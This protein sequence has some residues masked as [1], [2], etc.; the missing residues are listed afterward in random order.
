LRQIST[1]PESETLDRLTARLCSLPP[2]RNGGLN[3][4]LDPDSSPADA[5]H[6]NHLIDKLAIQ[7]QEKI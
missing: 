5:E 3:G 7:G 1:A 2:A 4:S 6:R